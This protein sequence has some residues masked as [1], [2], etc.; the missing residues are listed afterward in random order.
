MRVVIDKSLPGHPAASAVAKLGWRRLLLVCGVAAPLL[1]VGMDIVASL[2]Y[3]GY[4]YRDQ[5]VSELS[6]IGTPTRTFWLVGGTIYSLLGIGFG[7]AIWQSARRR[8]LRVVAGLLVAHAVLLLTV[9]P[10]SP[11]HQ[12]EV[13]AADGATASDTVHLIVVGVGGIVFLFEAAFAAAAFGKWFRLYTIATVVAALV[14]GF[15]T[16]L[17]A[18]EVQANEPTPWVGIYE[19]ISA[20]GYELWIVVLACILLRSE[21]KRVQQR[22]DSATDAAKG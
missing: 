12:R 15:I 16:S 6:A 11:M 3:E 17:Y 13:L 1:W 21:G 18:P 22:V 10:F 4:S 8:A 7:V 14:F 20:Y 19:R 5:T 2:L 9:G